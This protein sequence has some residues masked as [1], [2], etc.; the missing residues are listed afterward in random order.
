MEESEKLRLLNLGKAVVNEKYANLGKSKPTYLNGL[1]YTLALE[2]TAY[3]ISSMSDEHIKD[4]MRIDLEELK[5][6]LNK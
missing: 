3:D 4:L 5:K 1:A 6:S 2:L